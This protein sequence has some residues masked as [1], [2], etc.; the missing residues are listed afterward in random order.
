MSHDTLNLQIRWNQTP[1]E[2]RHHEENESWFYLDWKQ[3]TQMMIYLNAHVILLKAYQ[4]YLKEQLLMRMRLRWI[5]IF[6]R[7]FYNVGLPCSICSWVVTGWCFVVCSCGNLITMI[8]QC[9]VRRNWKGSE[10]V[11]LIWMNLS[12]VIP[13]WRTESF[14][15]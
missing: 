4:K 3:L 9:S 13:G 2:T 8:N 1:K 6:E 10:P 14:F 5:W 12:R 15:R 11:Y 7:P